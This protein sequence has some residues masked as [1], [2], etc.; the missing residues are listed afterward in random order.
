M[1]KHKNRAITV[2]F[3]TFIEIAQ[4][5]KPDAASGL[6]QGFPAISAHSTALRR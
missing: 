5:E 3:F 6:Y 4:K 1:N 2:R